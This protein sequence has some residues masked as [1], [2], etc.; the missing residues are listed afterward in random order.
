MQ[1][2]VDIRREGLIPE[3]LSYRQYAFN[4]CKETDESG[5]RDGW[6]ACRFTEMVFKHCMSPI[7]QC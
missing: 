6:D 1:D 7:A 2:G 5:S 4:T 3:C